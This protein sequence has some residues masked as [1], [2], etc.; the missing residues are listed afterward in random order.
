MAP[1]ALVLAAVSLALAGAALRDAREAREEAR[2]GPRKSGASGERREAPGG[3]RDGAAGP[4]EKEPAFQGW[5]GAGS[6]KSAEAA[7]TE[8]EAAARAFPGLP[9]GSDPAEA[10]RP[11]VRDVVAQELKAR[12]AAAEAAGGRKEEEKKPPLS[13]VAAVLG[14]TDAQEE[15]MREEIVRGQSEVIDLLRL[16]MSDGKVP[17][18]EVFDVLLGEP[19]KARARM[20][21]VFGRLLSERVPGGTETYAER[22]EAMKKRTNEGFARALTPEQFREYE[23][24]GQDPLEIQVPDSPWIRVLQEAVERRRR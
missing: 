1:A 20:I 14:L 10:L 23:K 13:Q 15:A 16:P 12:D 3:S 18:D 5:S 17:V 4:Q 2:A 8:A 22:W 24:M 19:E 21:E 7:R 9:A 6:A 11:L